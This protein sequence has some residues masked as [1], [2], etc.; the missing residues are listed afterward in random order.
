MPSGNAKLELLLASK[1]TLFW[2][3]F[4]SV[5]SEVTNNSE[6]LLWVVQRGTGSPSPCEP[7]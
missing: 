7:S 5:P 6:M 2:K 4:R 3:K 1:S